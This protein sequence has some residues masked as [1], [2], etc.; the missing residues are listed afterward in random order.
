MLLLK[1]RW[2]SRY[3]Q[4]SSSHV[5]LFPAHFLPCCQC[6]IN[7]LSFQKERKEKIYTRKLSEATMKRCFFRLLFF[8]FLL[9][10][11]F[12]DRKEINQ[13]HSFYSLFKVSVSWNRIKMNWTVLYSARLKSGLWAALTCSKKNWILKM[14]CCWVVGF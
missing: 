9:A 4:L 14:C 8:S 7:V 5:T 13:Q 10:F 6:N 11:Y 1:C 2:R 3:M 12:V